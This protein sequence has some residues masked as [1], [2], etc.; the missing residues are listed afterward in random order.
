MKQKNELQL[1]TLRQ[2]LERQL[3]S[4]TTVTIG[5][6]LLLEQILEELRVNN[7]L[8]REGQG[9]TPVTHA[10]GKQPTTAPGARGKGWLTKLLGG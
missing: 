3:P 9:K 5:S 4:E 10:E 2:V 6:F 8:L 7:N 1:N